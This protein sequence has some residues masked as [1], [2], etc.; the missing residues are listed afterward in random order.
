MPL[1]QELAETVSLSATRVMD[2]RLLSPRGLTQASG[3]RPDRIPSEVPGPHPLPPLLVAASL[4]EGQC[5]SQP[6]PRLFV[7]HYPKQLELF[8]Q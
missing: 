2:F 1:P 4:Q 5:L 6:S 7:I 8:T 3:L